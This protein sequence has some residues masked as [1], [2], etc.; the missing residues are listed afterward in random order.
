MIMQGSRMLFCLSMLLCFTAS[1]AFATSVPR[2]SF[3]ELVDKTALIFIGTVLESDPSQ[4]DEKRN[5]P[6]TK[7]TF[8]IDETLKGTYSDSQLTLFIPGGV[9]ADGSI[10]EYENS[11]VYVEGNTY[12]VFVRD[13][14]WYVTPITNWLHSTFREEEVADRRVWVNQFG[15]AVTAVDDS[16]FS[17]GPRVSLPERALLRNAQFDKAGSGVDPSEAAVLERDTGSLRNDDTGKPAVMLRA[18]A[19]A[20]SESCGECATVD[21]I[22]GAVDERVHRRAVSAFSAEKG[23]APPATGQ[24]MT[25]AQPL[26]TLVRDDSKASAPAIP[27][28]PLR[29]P[30]LKPNVGEEID[31][32]TFPSEDAE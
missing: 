14:P 11:P 5:E 18:E 24:V 20:A 15:Q 30:N 21:T 26:M 7:V 6:V 12:L 17:V 16:G 23:S 29:D 31:V 10:L 2:M 13:G 4:F 9:Y 8:L 27:L 22:I 25:R 1:Q 3:D 32:D 28:K 19:L